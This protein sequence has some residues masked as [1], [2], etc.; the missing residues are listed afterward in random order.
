MNFKFPD[1]FLALTVLKAS[2]HILKQSEVN[3]ISLHFPPDHFDWIAAGKQVRDLRIF[4]HPGGDFVNGS[5]GSDAVHAWYLHFVLSQGSS[6][7][8]AKGLQSRSLHCFL[9][10]STD[11]S[12]FVQSDQTETISQVEED[13]IRGRET[14]GYEISESQNL[15]YGI[16]VELEHPR[17]CHQEDHYTHQ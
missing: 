6:L 16:D 1:D 4:I 13:R 17:Q 15:H 7:V 14:V 11:Y 3:F 9:G 10:L 2:T 5:L 12:S 8:E